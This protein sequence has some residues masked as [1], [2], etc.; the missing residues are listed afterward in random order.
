MVDIHWLP[1]AING[2]LF[3]DGGQSPFKCSKIIYTHAGNKQ[4]Y[5]FLAGS[6]ICRVYHRDNG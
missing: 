5:L 1:K 2:Y 6:Y 3:F 4:D